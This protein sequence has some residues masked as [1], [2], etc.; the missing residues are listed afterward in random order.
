MWCVSEKRCK[1]ARERGILTSDKKREIARVLSLSSSPSQSLSHL[2]CFRFLFLF[3]FFLSFIIKIAICALFLNVLKN[4]L[5][6]SFSRLSVLPVL[7][8]VRLS[9]LLLSL[10]ASKNNL[11]KIQKKKTKNNFVTKRELAKWNISF[12]LSLSLSL[13]QHTP[14][15]DIS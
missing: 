10:T 3:R 13:P 7:F 1:R 14:L 4:C 12:P 2:F 15:V 11:K 8:F 6:Y 9:L 5:I